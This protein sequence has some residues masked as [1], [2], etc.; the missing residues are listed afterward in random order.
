MTG[1]D[2]ARQA[3][4]V[5]GR[6][7]AAGLAASWAGPIAIAAALL[8]VAVGCT[9]LM[10][11]A[12]AGSEPPPG[13]G[14]T[15]TGA[16]G[17]A[18]I[19]ATIRTVETGGRYDTRVTT[20]TASGAYAFIDSAWRHYAASVGVDTATYTSAWMAPPADQDAT[21]NAYVNEILARHNG[22][23]AAIPVAWYLPSALRN[24]AAMD[25][26][27][28]MG[29]NVLTPRQY[30][31]RWLN[32]YARQGTLA[33]TSST[34]TPTT[35]G[36][37]VPVA[38]AS[39]PLDHTSCLDDLTGATYTAPPGVT[40]L[41]ACEI[42]WGGYQPGRIPNS[43]MRYSPHSG[44]MHP[45]AS[46]AW[47][48]LWDAANR[49]GLDLDGNSYRPASRS[50]GASCSNHNWGLAI[51]V[52]AMVGPRFDTPEYEWLAANAHRYGYANPRFARPVSLGG[53][54]RGGWA[55]GT[56]CHLEPWHWEFVAFLSLPPS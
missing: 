6:R 37:V 42:S 5:A 1:S 30:Q 55:G 10:L 20:S 17:N 46:A 45:A 39:P 9:G 18:R 48:Q 27:P 3:A 32:E 11:F 7:V 15:W 34:T 43:A 53:T 29:G 16:G 44:Y 13:C 35:T 25:V 4:G 26:V 28:A 21:A 49:A 2:A 38:V 56:C 33:T 51:D 19:L 31:Q 8:V 40:E 23:I 36:G 12:G 24:P 54:G 52:S 47:D 22:D 50:S 41:S 14:H